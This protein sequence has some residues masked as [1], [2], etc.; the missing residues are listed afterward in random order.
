MNI[1]HKVE[2]NDLEIKTIINSLD[3]SLTNHKCLYS[4]A[5]LAEF[6]DCEHFSLCLYQQ[7]SSLIGRDDLYLNVLEKI[8]KFY[9]ETESRQ[10]D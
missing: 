8:T 10:T 9:N 2:L 4:Y 3:F 7:M 6:L 1:I 5:T